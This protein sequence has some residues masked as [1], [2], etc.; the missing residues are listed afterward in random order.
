MI[1]I[2]FGWKEDKDREILTT[3]SLSFGYKQGNTHF[4]QSYFI[5]LITEETNLET[6]EVYWAYM[7]WHSM[8][9]FYK[10]KALFVKEPKL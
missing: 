9:W 3:K 4:G 1:E 7:N 8:M 5:T 2:R 6:G 10:L